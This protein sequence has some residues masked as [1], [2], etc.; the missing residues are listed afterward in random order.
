MSRVR[1][2]IATHCAA[3]MLCGVSLRGWLAAFFAPASIV[4]ADTKW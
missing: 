1:E 4:V 2:R 3:L